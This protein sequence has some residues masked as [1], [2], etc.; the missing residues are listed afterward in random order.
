M[1]DGESGGEW[2]GKGK[3]R[4]QEKGKCRREGKGE[5][6]GRE[7]TGETNLQIKQCGAHVFEIDMSNP[8]RLLI[9][10]LPDPPRLR[11]QLLLLRQ[12]LRLLRTIREDEK[13]HH[14]RNNTRQPLDQEQ[15][16]PV[17]DPALVIPTRD[18]VRQRAREA[19]RQRR[20]GQEDADAHADLVPQVEEAEQV[21][22]AGPVAGLEEAEEEARGHH[23]REG[24]GRGLQRR[25]DAPPHHAEGRPD[26]RREDL[27]H[28]REPLEDDVGDVE[29]GEQPLVVGRGEVEVFLH[30]C[31]LCV[32]KVGSAC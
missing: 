9:T 31:Y 16:P 24:E 32:S 4:G 8:L 22:D 19:R 2:K 20:R 1:R 25:D 15:Q 5:G 21:G 10:N 27:P 11:N 12:E 28:Q 30:P 7:M 13:R 26:V 3:R 23:A 29:D 14:P 17:R 18:P 6:K